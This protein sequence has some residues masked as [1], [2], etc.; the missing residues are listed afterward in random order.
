MGFRCPLRPSS[1][2]LSY[3]CIT[4]ARR[5]SRNMYRHIHTAI[6]MYVSGSFE[7]ETAVYIAQSQVDISGSVWPEH[8]DLCDGIMIKDMAHSG[9]SD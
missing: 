7:L 3:L 8:P 4:G 1:Q 9:E 2:Q 5:I 6:H